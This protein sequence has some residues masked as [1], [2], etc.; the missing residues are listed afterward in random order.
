[1]AKRIIAILIIACLLLSPLFAGPFGLEFGWTKEDMIKSGAR[2][3]HEGPIAHNVLGYA[4]IPPKQY[5]SFEN[6]YVYTNPEVGL[7]RIVAV[8]K[9]TASTTQLINQYQ[10]TKNQLKSVYGDPIEELDEINPDSIW[11]APSD[12]IRALYLGERIVATCWLP[13]VS[14]ETDVAYVNYAINSDDGY[15]GYNIIVYES[16]KADAVRAAESSVL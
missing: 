2:I 11:N 16:N 10:G 13:E 5:S 3:I 14:D 7:F 15:L 9:Y 12:L 1:M 8:S 6:Y 4:I